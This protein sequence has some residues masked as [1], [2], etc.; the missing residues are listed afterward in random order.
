MAGDGHLGDL[1]LHSTSNQRHLPK[2]IEHLDA[3]IE[4][5][6]ERKTREELKKEHGPLGGYVLY[7]HEYEEYKGVFQIAAAAK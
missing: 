5:Y 6:I 4:N 2:R 3:E 7:D 1:S